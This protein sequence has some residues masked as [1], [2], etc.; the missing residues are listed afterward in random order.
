[1]EA[2][3]KTYLVRLEGFLKERLTKVETELKYLRWFI[4]VIVSITVGIIKYL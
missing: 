2:V 4:V 1:M 3:T